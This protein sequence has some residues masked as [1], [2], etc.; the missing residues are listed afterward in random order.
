MD[1]VVQKLRL[2]SRYLLATVRRINLATLYV[3]EVI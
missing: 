1:S 2:E 3:Q